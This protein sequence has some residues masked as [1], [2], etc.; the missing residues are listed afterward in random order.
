M[1]NAYIQHARVYIKQTFYTNSIASRTNKMRNIAKNDAQYPS[2]FNMA[3]YGFLHIHIYTRKEAWANAVYTLKFWDCSINRVIPNY[4]WVYLSCNKLDR[5]GRR[6]FILRMMGGG[7]GT[8]GCAAVCGWCKYVREAS[9]TSE[10]PCGLLRRTKCINTN[11]IYRYVVYPNIYGRFVVVNFNFL[12]LRCF[13]LIFFR[14]NG[15]I[16]LLYIVCGQV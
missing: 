6:W 2:S 7:R 13:V 3:G 5:C 10:F 12:N 14:L 11:G 4:K 1:S 8:S 15:S 16:Y 9:E